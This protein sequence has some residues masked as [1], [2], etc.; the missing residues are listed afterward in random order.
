MLGARLIVVRDS[1]EAETI[2]GLLR[3]EGIA[4]KHRQTDMGAGAGIASSS[5]QTR[6]HGST[7]RRGNTEGTQALD[8]RV[9]GR[10]F[11]SGGVPRFPGCSCPRLPALVLVSR[12]SLNGKEGVSGSSPEEGFAETPANG[13]F[14]LSRS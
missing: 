2:C 10:S 6:R 5:G 12:S 8:T 7:L 14:G 11:V 9:N 1:M 4:C 3:T 13:R